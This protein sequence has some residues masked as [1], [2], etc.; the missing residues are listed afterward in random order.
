MATEIGRSPA[1]AGSGHSAQPEPSSTVSAVPASVPNAA[2]I[3]IMRRLEESSERAAMRE[4]ARQY[5]GQFLAAEGLTGQLL[6]RQAGKVY[7]AA[8]AALIEVTR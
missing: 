6:N 5:L 2:L 8:V 7:D 1:D 3:G 4:L